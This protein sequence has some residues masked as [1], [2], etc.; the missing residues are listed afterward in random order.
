MGGVMSFLTFGAL[1]VVLWYG[2][3]QVMAG[4]M[5]PAIW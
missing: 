2:G 1:A 3:R 5:T 4:S